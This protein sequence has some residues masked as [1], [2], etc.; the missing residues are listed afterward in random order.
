MALLEPLVMIHNVLYILL[1]LFFVNLNHDGRGLINK[2][3]LHQRRGMSLL[4]KSII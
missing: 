4:L 2:C 1:L 3:N